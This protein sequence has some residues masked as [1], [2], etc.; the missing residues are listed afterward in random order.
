M[1][2]TPMSHITSD[3][4]PYLPSVVGKNMSQPRHSIQAC[5]LRLAFPKLIVSII[6]LLSSFFLSVIA[7]LWV[8]FI[9]WE[10]KLSKAWALLRDLLLLLHNR[11][12]GAVRSE[13]FGFFKSSSLATP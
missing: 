9:G 8:C 3:P 1:R 4:K 6:A 2:I 5:G 12:G 13:H 7:F 11:A 10:M